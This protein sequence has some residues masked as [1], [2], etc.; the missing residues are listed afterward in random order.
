ML[1]DSLTKLASSEILERLLNALRGDLPEVLGKDQAVTA[2]DAT[3]G[4]HW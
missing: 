4:L 1:A 3:G 2:S